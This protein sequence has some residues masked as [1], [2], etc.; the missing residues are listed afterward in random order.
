MLCRLAFALLLLAGPVVRAQT[1]LPTIAPGPPVPATP[2]PYGQRVLLAPGDSAARQFGDILLCYRLAPS[3]TAVQCTIY[4]ATQL[5]GIRQLNATAPTFTFDVQVGYGKAH[6]TL[7]LQLIAAPQP[8][9]ISTL[10]GRFTY[11]GN[12]QQFTFKGDLI[13]WYAVP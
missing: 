12:N 7:A 6:G 2:T 4:V 5:A 13:G 9:Q 10:S 1:S 8:G 3:G 11:S